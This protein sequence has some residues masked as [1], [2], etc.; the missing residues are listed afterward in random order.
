[1]EDQNAPSAAAEDR[2]DSNDPCASRKKGRWFRRLLKILIL[3][4]MLVLVAPWVASIQPVRGWILSSYNSSIRGSIDVESLSLSW[5]SAPA[6]TGLVVRDPNGQAVLTAPEV[7]TDKSLLSLAA[8][9]MSFGRVEI[10]NPN[11]VLIEKPGGDYTISDAFAP[12]GQAAGEAK[13]EGGQEA[14]ELPEVRGTI[15][16]H[17]ARLTV[18][19]LSGK[20]LELT[21]ANSTVTLET[22]NTLRGEQTVRLPD[23]AVIR[24]KYDLTGLVKDGR[25][26]PTRLSG[27]LTVRMNRPADL[28]PLGDFAL[29]APGRLTGS[30]EVDANFRY[31]EGKPII[32]TAKLVAK[33]VRIDG[34]PV[35][36]RDIRLDANG[37]NWIGLTGSL[38]AKAIELTSDA[39]TVTVNDL[40]VGTGKDMTMLGDVKAD[41]DLARVARIASAF[42]DPN[43]EPVAIAGRLTFAGKAKTAEKGYDIEGDGKVEDLRTGAEP[44]AVALA[45]LTF[46]ENIHIDPNEKL[47]RIRSAKINSKMLDLT[48]SGTVAD[49]TGEKVL[50][51]KGN[52]N[53]DWNQL[54]PLI[55]AFVPAAKE[56]AI[57]G[58]IQSGFTLTGPASRAKLAP[59]YHDVDANAGVGWDT[60]RMLGFGLGKAQVPITFQKGKVVIPATQIP[61]EGGGTVNL[62]ATVDMAPADAPQLVMPAKQTVLDNVQINEEIGRQFLSRINPVFSKVISL[63]GR[64]TMTTQDVDIPLGEQILQ[65]G[66]GSGRID[67]TGLQIQPAGVLGKLMEFGGLGGT[68][69]VKVG[70]VDFA[71]QNGA[72]RCDNFAMTFGK[73]FDLVFSGTVKFDDSVDMM[74]SVPLKGELL[75]KLGVGGEVSKYVE[76][77]DLTR[78]KIPMMGTRGAPE[79]DMSKVDIKPILK[80]ATEKMLKD[81]AGGAIGD[82]L[83][84]G[85]PKLPGLEGLPGLPGRKPTSRPATDPNSKDEPKPGKKILDGIFDAI[86]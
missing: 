59:V 71:I 31:V 83:D 55:K 61:A 27:T 74:V 12:V 24:T 70:A 45:P 19:R 21:D 17:R 41:V 85:L 33:G 50:G 73:D 66:T 47:L 62:A 29:P 9:P 16:I 42:G 39:A 22:L 18:I 4:A 63:K 72:V 37:L 48:A 67:L 28:E 82:I 15:A 86:K 10:R 65:R 1:M 52:Y 3:I 57:T 14:G 80:K 46:S 2:N 53:G 26:D 75:K 84:K 34:K 43:A 40:T 77:M 64:V 23:G 20:P 7:Q 6:V 51:I 30:A 11:L 35:S 8:G 76:M 44:N 38:A 54:L 56:V 5:F 81:K 68:Q 78:V 25:F 36:E 69:L 32:S 79:L 60:A 49:L 58:R 13:G